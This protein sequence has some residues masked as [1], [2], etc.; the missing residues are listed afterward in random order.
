M[1]LPEDLAETMLEQAY[2][3]R[4]LELIAW[5]L[6]YTCRIL[7]A[8]TDEETAMAFNKASSELLTETI[9]SFLN[10]NKLSVAKKEAP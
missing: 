1:R 6:G 7:E 9:K 2:V 3:N 10:R 4:P 8:L 5:A